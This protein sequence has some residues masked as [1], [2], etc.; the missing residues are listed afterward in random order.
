M[1]LF[2]GVLLKAA[3]GGVYTVIV[4]VDDCG[5]PVVGQLVPLSLIPDNEKVPAVEAFIVTLNTIT[6]PDPTALDAVPVLVKQTLE[7]EIAIAHV[8]E[9]ETVTMPGDVRVKLEGKLILN[10]LLFGVAVV[11]TLNDSSLFEPAQIV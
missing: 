7:P 5:V 1:A 8:L 10:E 2:V 11:V 6:S 9:F 3:C 4:D